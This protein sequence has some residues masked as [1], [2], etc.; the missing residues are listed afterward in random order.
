MKP[1]LLLTFLL[2][3][4]LTLC[5]G[6]VKADTTFADNAVWLTATA[7]IA[8]STITQE[9]ATGPTAQLCDFK[10]AAHYRL[11]YK[12]Q[13]LLPP[14]VYVPAKPCCELNT[15]DLC[16]TKVKARYHRLIRL[17]RRRC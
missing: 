6:L 7:G 12:H 5:V 14:L 10:M 1:R 9:N 17:H 8:P 2:A 13:N 11:H 3:L 16:Q 15:A 4:A